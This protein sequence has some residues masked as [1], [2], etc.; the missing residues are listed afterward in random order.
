MEF[1]WGG[2]QTGFAIVLTPRNS[3]GANP[4]NVVE[5]VEFSSNVISHTASAFNLLGHDDTAPSG[6]LARIVIR[7]NL[8][9]DVST[10]WNGAGI[11]AQIGGEPRDITIDH[12]TV[13][14]DG[15]IISFYSGQYTTLTGARVTGGPILGFVFTNNLLKHNT[16]GIFGSGQ[17]YGNGTLA[18]YTPGAIVMRNVMATNSSIASRYPPD[19]QF[20]TVAAFLANFQNPGAQN[21]RL[22]AGSPYIN[23]GLDGKSIGCDIGAGQTG[24]APNAPAGLRINK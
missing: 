18:Y 8:V 13:M 3:S 1:N 22:V 2:A 15:N 5:D 24:P 6:Q 23:A 4:W 19:N 21:Y 20:P 12:N 10:S 17:A 9:F 11:F 7:N 16:Y 14:H